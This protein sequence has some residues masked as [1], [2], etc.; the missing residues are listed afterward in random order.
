MYSF[1][2]KHKLVLSSFMT[3][4]QGSNKSNTMG[5]TS[6]A[7]TAYPSGATEFTLSL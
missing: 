3:Y 1:C 7:E 6:G 2:R 4:Y 5:A